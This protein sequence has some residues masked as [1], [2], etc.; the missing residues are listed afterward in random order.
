MAE[1]ITILIIFFMLIV[2][3]FVFYARVLKGTS[4]IRIEENLQLQAIE[5]ATTASFLPE[6]Q[7]SEENIRIEGC[8]DLYKVKKSIELMERNVVFY[9]DALGFS[10]IELEVIYSDSPLYPSGFKTTI[11]NRTL[12]GWKQ[13]TTTQIPTKLFIPDKKAFAFGVMNIET[14]AK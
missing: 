3:G 8:V 10:I 13:K 12:P 14:F 9:Y 5:I 11:Y 6:L 2:F 7:C 1:T 4:G